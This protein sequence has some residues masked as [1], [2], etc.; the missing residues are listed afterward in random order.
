MR[1]RTM[2]IDCR[3]ARERWAARRRRG[4]RPNAAATWR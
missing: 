4:L 1:V 3:Y 2:R